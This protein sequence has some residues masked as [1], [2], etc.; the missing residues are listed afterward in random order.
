MK[1]QKEKPSR[2]VEK[3]PQRVVRAN[4]GDRQDI[5]YKEDPNVVRD[6]ILMDQINKIDIENMKQDVSEIVQEKGGRAR[7]KKD[8]YE[9]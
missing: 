9:K 2:N 7:G 6:R 5:A 3:N 1:L 4:K 8:K